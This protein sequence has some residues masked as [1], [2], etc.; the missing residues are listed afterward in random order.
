MTLKK[1]IMIFIFSFLIY[2]GGNA[3][4]TSAKV[5][6]DG[7]TCSLCAKGVEGQLKGL[8]FVQS[9]STDLKNSTFTLRFKNNSKIDLPKIGKAVSDGGF[10]LRN[11]EVDA[12]GKLDES[13]G[14]YKIQTGN[15]PDFTLTNVNGDFS[16]NDLVSIKG[17]FSFKDNSVKIKSIKKTE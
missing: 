16:S 4:V 3:Q 10:T 11:L 5:G 6:V 17:V 15:T 12:K 14:V 7:F 1:I 2:S 8:N 9:V 13:N